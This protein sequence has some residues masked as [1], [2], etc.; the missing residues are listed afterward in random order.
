MFTHQTTKQSPATGGNQDRAASGAAKLSTKTLYITDRDPVI[1][2]DYRSTRLTH[3]DLARA[4]R[5]AG[6]AWARRDAIIE[7]GYERG[8]L[9]HDAINLANIDAEAADDW[10]RDVYSALYPIAIDIMVEVG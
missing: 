7:A 2:H 1:V 5:L 9:D 6:D 10:A 3:A 4:R 8:A